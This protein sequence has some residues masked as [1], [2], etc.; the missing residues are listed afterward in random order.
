MQL[1]KRWGIGGDVG[2]FQRTED[3]GQ[4]TEGYV[5]CLW[6]ER[7]FLRRLAAG[8]E[9]KGRF[10]VDKTVGC[11]GMLCS[12]PLIPLQREIFVCSNKNNGLSWMVFSI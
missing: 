3:R 10:S 8:T 4:R 7:A 1:R 9:F 12:S 6:H 11:R 2:R 5:Q